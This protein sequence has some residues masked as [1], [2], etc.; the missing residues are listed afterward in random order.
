MIC[1]IL[2]TP[3]LYPHIRHCFISWKILPHAR[4]A[5]LRFVGFAQKDEDFVRLL[6][7]VG[8]TPQKSRIMLLFE[9]RGL[10]LPR[11]HEIADPGFQDKYFR[12]LPGN[13]DDFLREIQDF[14]YLLLGSG[15]KNVDLQES[16]LETRQKIHALTAAALSEG[17]VEIVSSGKSSHFLKIKKL[18][19]H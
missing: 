16:E 7:A 14:D 5:P 18:T 13:T 3:E 9:K 10:Y 6:E 2:L 8:R 15:E 12:T 11:R 17:K 19:N 1:G 4:K